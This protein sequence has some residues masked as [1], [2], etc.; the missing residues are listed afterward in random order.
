LQAVK[1]GI[2]LP[3]MV[4]LFGKRIGCYKRS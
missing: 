2:C 4:W 3:D 1:Q